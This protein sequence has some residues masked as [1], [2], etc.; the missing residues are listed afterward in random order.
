[1]AFGYALTIAEKAVL[2]AK[3]GY[4]PIIIKT[5]EITETATVGT[6]TLRSLTVRQ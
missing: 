6:L 1:M 4:I 2:L 3:D 5:Y